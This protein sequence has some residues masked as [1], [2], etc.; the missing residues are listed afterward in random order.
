LA[1]TLY[2]DTALSIPLDNSDHV[3]S[4]ENTLNELLQ[5][6]E[7]VHSKNN[8]ASVANV[9]DVIKHAESSGFFNKQ[10]VDVNVDED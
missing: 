8:E 2:F 6:I 1:K 5:D 7:D 9:N 10:S 3:N 4:C